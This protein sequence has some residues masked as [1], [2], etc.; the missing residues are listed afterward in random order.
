M[1][2]KILSIIVPSYN[3]ET[4]L[5]KCLGSLV[6]DDKALLQKLDIIIVN[7][8]SK[9]RTSEIAHGFA[10][11]FPGVFRVIDKPNGHYGSCINAALKV[12]VGLYVK[13]LDADDYVDRKNFCDF[14]RFISDEYD[15]GRVYDLLVTDYDD[16]DT[17]GA[18]I[19]ESKYGFPE[20]DGHTLYDVPK[21]MPRFTTHSVVYLLE[22]IKGLGYS[23]KEGVPYTDTQ[24]IIE[25][26]VMVSSVRYLP[27]CVTKYL[28]GRDGQTMEYKTYMAQFHIVADIAK[29][30]LSRYKS[31]MSICKP[32]A[33]RYYQKELLRLICSVYYRALYGHKEGCL[34]KINICAFD[35][36][37]KETPD[38]YVMSDKL[39]LPVMGGI[40]FKF[41][42]EWRAKKRTDTMMFNV[43]DAYIKVAHP[44]YRVRSV[45]RRIGL[46]GA[47]VKCLGKVNNKRWLLRRI[48]G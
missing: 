4:Y 11:D 5:P 45:L 34:C 43:V 41:I 38:L 25:P 47:V 21:R 16:V 7:D 36:A 32:S 13:V 3:M 18:V 48:K 33:S 40:G 23:Q 17:G 24:W 39:D 26:M 8:G 35:S 22:N 14:V 9:D 31:L 10:E 6:I 29:D 2:N 12:T 1:E 42:K 28:I 20:G 37:L 27:L 30:M 19:R 15:R 46:V 44:V